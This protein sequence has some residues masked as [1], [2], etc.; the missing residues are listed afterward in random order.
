MTSRTVI[1]WREFLEG[2]ERESRLIMSLYPPESEEIPAIAELRNTKHFK[3]PSTPAAVASAESR[4]GVRLPDDLQNFYIATNGWSLVGLGDTQVAPIEEL[5]YAMQ[6]H[7][8]YADDISEHLGAADEL[9]LIRQHRE[10]LL[11]LSNTSRVAYFV[12]NPIAGRWKYAWA[13]FDAHGQKFD[14]FV[15]SM[16]S[17]KWI[18]HFYLR[19][20]L[21]YL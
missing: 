5:A 6:T 8:E 11:L 10:Q 18:C 21:D 19:A 14:D 9:I 1:E 13:Q 12:V 15:S 7:A 20:R 16:E 3:S 17:L 4:L 2:W